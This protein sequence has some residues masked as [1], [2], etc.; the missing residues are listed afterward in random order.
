MAPFHLKL[1]ST[2]ICLCG[3]RMGLCA[4]PLIWTG[5]VGW[6]VHR[7]ATSNLVCPMGY[8]ASNSDVVEKVIGRIRVLRQYVPIRKRQVVD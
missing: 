4:R 7:I 1:M 5:V 6:A 2:W 8:I 3:R